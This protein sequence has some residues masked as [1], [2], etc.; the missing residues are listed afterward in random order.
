[1]RLTKT[2]AVEVVATPIE[3]ARD[4]LALAPA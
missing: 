4:L 1:V 2:G 3:I